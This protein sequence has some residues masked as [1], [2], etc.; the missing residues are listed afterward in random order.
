MP[1]SARHSP[2]PLIVYHHLHRDSQCCSCSTVMPG[3]ICFNCG[4]LSTLLVT[5]RPPRNS[6]DRC[7]PASKRPSLTQNKSILCGP[8]LNPAQGSLSAKENPIQPFAKQ[9]AFDSQL[10]KIEDLLDSKN[11]LGRI[12]TL[13]ANDPMLLDDR[14]SNSSCQRFSCSSGLVSNSSLAYSPNNPRYLSPTSSLGSLKS[15]DGFSEDDTPHAHDMERWLTDLKP[16]GRS[17]RGLE[18]RNPSGKC[19]AK[20]TRRGVDCRININGKVCEWVIFL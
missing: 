11:K 18:D 15:S 14:D 16:A 13:A 12:H 4:R 8:Q 2:E 10:T 7:V 19:S 5:P 6:L 20:L 9:N 17:A 1:R 3:D